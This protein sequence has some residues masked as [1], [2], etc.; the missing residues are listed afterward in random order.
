MVVP[1][2]LVP[3]VTDSTSGIP[4]L[5]TMLGS[6]LLQV[7]STDPGRKTPLSDEPGQVFEE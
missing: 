2:L 5:Y 6:E 3:A 1:M 4:F 7:I